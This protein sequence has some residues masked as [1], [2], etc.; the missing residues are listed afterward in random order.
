MIKSI[1]KKPFFTFMGVIILIFLFSACNRVVTETAPQ[2]SE[3]I[4][5]KLIPFYGQYSA[6][7]DDNLITIDESGLSYGEQNFNIIAISEQNIVAFDDKNILL[8]FNGEAILTNLPAY[9]DSEYEWV[10]QL[11]KSEIELSSLTR[12]EGEYTEE[13]EYS[14]DRIQNK[15]LDTGYL[16][17]DENGQFNLDIELKDDFSLEHIDPNTTAQTQIKAGTYQAQWLL[18]DMYMGE[19]DLSYDASISLSEGS[20]TVM[21]IPGILYDSFAIGEYAM[22]KWNEPADGNTWYSPLIGEYSSENNKIIFSADGAVEYIKDDISYKGKLSEQR[23]NHVDTMIIVTDNEGIEYHL[24][25]IMILNAELVHTELFSLTDEGYLY[26]G[27][28][29]LFKPLD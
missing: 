6:V 7:G 21:L 22:I 19:Y 25:I 2:S 14:F 20:D 5:A 10:Y 1:I 26:I 24:N 16:T 23:P 11:I 18:A 13:F 4:A 15:N 27:G 17:I 12:F 3:D 28:D 9:Q 29:G 8:R